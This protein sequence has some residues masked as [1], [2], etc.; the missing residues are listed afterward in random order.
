MMKS[1]NVL[2]SSTTDTSKAL[3][4][5]KH[6]GSSTIEML[7]VVLL[8][9][10][11]SI[12]IASLIISGS[13]AQDRIATK[14]DEQVDARTCLSFIQVVLKQ[15]DETGLAIKQLEGGD[16]AIFIPKEDSD[17]DLWYFFVDGVLYECYMEK[18]TLPDRDRAMDIMKI[19]GIVTLEFDE[20]KNQVQTNIS[21]VYGEHIKNLQSVYTLRSQGGTYE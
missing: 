3:Q 12:T 1:K 19:D 17:Y 15:H 5:E 2:F 14:H 6:E 10:V 21:Y 8:V 7:M 11:M 9:I 4:T 13:H 20:Y 16:N 18:G